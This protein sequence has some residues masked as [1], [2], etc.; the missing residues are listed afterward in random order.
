MTAPTIYPGLQQEPRPDRAAWA[1]LLE[2]PADHMFDCCHD[3]AN[4]Q[5]PNSDRAQDFCLDCFDPLT[6][7]EP[8][9]VHVFCASHSPRE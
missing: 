4:R 9:Y 5:D 2:V 8:P 6:I 1:G 3:C 7:W